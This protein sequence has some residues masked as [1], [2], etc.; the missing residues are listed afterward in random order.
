MKKSFLLINLL[1]LSLAANNVYADQT[2]RSD[3]GNDFPHFAYTI[4][5]RS[6][7]GMLILVPNFK[8]NVLADVVITNLENG[9]IQN[10]KAN[11]TAGADYIPLYDGNCDYLVTVK[12]GKDTYKAIVCP[13]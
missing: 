12:N 6:E 3:L 9:N 1:L 10:T 2:P 7:N 5:I 13:E 4:E 8:S 11:F